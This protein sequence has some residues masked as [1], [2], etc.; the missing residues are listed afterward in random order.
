VGAPFGALEG[1]SAPTKPAPPEQPQVRATLAVTPT[2]PNNFCSFIEMI[3][4]TQTQAA[5]FILRKNHLTATKASSVNQLVEAM[6]GLPGEPDF[7]PFLTAQA[8]INNFG[9]VDLLI[10]LYQNHTLIKGVLMRSA[11]YVVAAERFATWLAATTR[12]HNQDFNSEF[13]L[14]GLDNNEVEV[15]E[16]AISDNPGDWPATADQIANRLPQHLVREVTQTSR[17]GRVS[18]TSNVAL[19]LGWLVAKGVLGMRPGD[20]GATPRQRSVSHLIYAPLTHW[21]PDLNLA[22]APNEAEAQ[23]ALVQAYLAAF[24]PTSEADVSFW[25]GF[26]KSET[27]RAI[28]A[29]AAKT[30]LALVEGIPGM[31]LLLKEQ[32]EALPA[33]Q[34]PV[35]PII[36]VLPADDPFTTAHRASRTRYF[37]DQ[38][39]QRHVFSSSGAA[40]PTILVNGQVV[41]LWHWSEGDN[42]ITWRLLTQLDPALFPLIQVELERIARFIQPDLPIV[43]ENA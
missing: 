6:V 24:G 38:K 3:H 22:D 12:Q 17:G 37:S 26:G 30:T 18:T 25:T 31:L 7:L 20:A 32:A 9:P 1:V 40:Q 27:A 28:G 11:S 13:R 29:L 15:L 10:P 14:W 4:A 33:I 8:R 23:A 19:V 2:I 36:N 35:Q 42:Q 5:H 39:L 21:Y 16:K 41:G 43:Q 34:P